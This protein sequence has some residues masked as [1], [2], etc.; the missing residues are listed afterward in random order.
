MLH[1]NVLKH[2]KQKL[3][4]NSLFPESYFRLSLP[5]NC[6]RN[7]SSLEKT[8]LHKYVF[9]LIPWVTAASC[10]AMLLFLDFFPQ[11]KLNC[12]NRSWEKVWI[13]SILFGDRIQIHISCLQFCN[14]NSGT[15]LYL[16][17]PANPSATIFDCLQCTSSGIISANV[18]NARIPSAPRFTNK[19]IHNVST[20]RKHTMC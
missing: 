9:H 19:S 15:N 13:I 6:L 17:T 8:T 16:V 10:T 20:K 5:W 14:F 12:K 11:M 18:L 1:L 4:K 2:S 7:V 3:N